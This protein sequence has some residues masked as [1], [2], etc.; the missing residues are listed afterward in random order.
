[1]FNVSVYKFYAEI[2]AK[3]QGL[4]IELLKRVKFACQ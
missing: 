4:E 3:P 1:M 2:R